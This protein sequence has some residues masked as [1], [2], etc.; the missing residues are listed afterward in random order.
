MNPLISVIIPVYNPGKYLQPCLSSIVNQTYKNL[1]IILIDD[2]STD[3]SAAL[4][5]DYAAKDKRIKCIHQKNSGVSAARNRGLAE[6]TGDFYSFPDSDDYLELDSYEYLLELVNEH[7]CDAINFE[8]FG[9]YK[10]HETTHLLGDDHYGLVDTKTAHR[11]VMNG[12][13]FCWNKLYAAHL[14]QGLQF[15]KDILRGEDSLFAHQAIDRA[16]TVWFDKRPLYHYVQSEQSACR[17]TFRP[18]QLSA[19]KLYD[20]YQPLYQEKYPEFWQPFLVGMAD[21]L[22][23]LYYNMWSDK[24]NYK[25]EQKALK[26]EYNRRY[27]EIDKTRLSKSKR[28]KFALFRSSANVFSVIHKLIHRL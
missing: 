27:V 7:Q 5:D 19:L 11:L 21:L 15:R 14:V 22:I 10:D 25:K 23:T 20:A 13:P 26:A 28:I 8:F 18:S 1:E 2:G 12:E 24:A 6:A 9:T 17:G 16:K 3:G 4:C